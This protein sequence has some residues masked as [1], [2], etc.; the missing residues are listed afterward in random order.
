MIV[1]ERPPGVIHSE[2]CVPG[3]NNILGGKSVQVSF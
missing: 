1:F 3:G 2:S